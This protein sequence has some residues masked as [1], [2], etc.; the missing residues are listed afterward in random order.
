[1]VIGWKLALVCT[2]T[3][4]LVLGCGWARL[5]MLA[6]F[7]SKVRKAHE[8]SAN[9][10]A[11]A[12]TAIRTVASLS[13]GDHVL[14]HYSSILATTSSKSLKSI[15]KAST[16]YAASQSVVF[17]VAALGFWYGGELISTHEYSMLQF[18]ICFA[19]L[20][21]GS[22]S[23]GA[24]FSFAP[25]ISKATSAAGEL[26]T[27]FDRIPDIDTTKPTGT[28]I[29]SCEGLI[30]IRDV[31]FRYPSRPK[32]L[33]LENLTLTVRP[34]CFV[35][36]VGPSGCGKS[37]VISLLERFF[38]PS[39]GQILVDN[40]DISTLNVNDYRRL[41]SLVSQ[42]PTVYQGSIRDNI[43]LGSSDDVEEDAIIRVCKEANI[44]DFIMSLP[45]GFATIV[46]S[47]GTL[48][49]GGQKQ[50]LAIACALLRNT[51]ILLLD[52]ATSALDADSEKV[53]QEALNTARRG[54]TTLCVAH[55]LTTIRD[56]DEICFL[57]QG[58]VIERGSHEE[59]MSRGGQYANLVHMQ[60]L[61]E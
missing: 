31:S 14:A 11:E 59:L 58:R 10:A 40:Q 30:Q 53:V 19:A 4:P 3:I 12:I 5:R 46:G 8:D 9:Y 52:E 36:L 18:F 23:V 44:Y 41:I 33:V 27:L 57:D 47:R 49:S 28:G 51:K 42:E 50:R 26:K 61:Q 60:S 55:R 48:L 43:V 35:A 29:Q 22:Q 21:S 38:D 1:M 56:A 7:E 45:A 20:I 2:A 25:D 16:L 17:L 37:T 39:T 6:L 24:V 32:Q 34:G 13:L 15:L 54:R